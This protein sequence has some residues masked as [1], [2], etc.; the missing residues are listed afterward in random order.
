MPSDAYK[1]L[2]DEDKAIYAETRAAVAIEVLERR[3]ERRL[4]EFRDRVNLVEAKMISMSETSK[5]SNARL[6]KLEIFF[7]ILI[8][9]GGGN[10]VALISLLQKATQLMPK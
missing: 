10:F 3:I 8:G 2:S 9:L 1:A 6:R 7:W 4:S 5:D